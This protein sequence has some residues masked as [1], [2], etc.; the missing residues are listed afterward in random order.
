VAIINRATDFTVCDSVTHPASG[1]SCPRNS[2]GSINLGYFNLP[3]GYYL[4]VFV[5]LSPSI[6][7][8]GST[9]ANAPT[10][11]DLAT[12]QSCAGN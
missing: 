2:D 5:T 12:G 7:G 1:T 3:Q 6:C 11:Y 10:L 9:Q 8:G 4:T